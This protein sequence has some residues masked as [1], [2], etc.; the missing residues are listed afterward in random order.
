MNKT[1][2]VHARVEPRTKKKAEGVL[3]KLGMTP[4]EAIRL[5]Y[6]QI[7]LRGGLPFRVVIPNDLTRDTLKKSAKGQGVESFDSLDEMFESW[8]K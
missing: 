8:G 5:F 1:A 6:R 7:C 4:T 3:R 2:V